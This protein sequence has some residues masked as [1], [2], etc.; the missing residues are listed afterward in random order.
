[1]PLHPPASRGGGDGRRRHDREEG[2]RLHEQVAHE[3]VQRVGRPARAEH[4]L[5]GP[6]RTHAL[7]R[8]EDEGEHEEVQQE[9]VEPERHAAIDRA[10][11]GN[12]GTAEERRAEAQREPRRGQRLAPPQN[13]GDHPEEH[14]GAD[15]ELN[16][17]SDGRH[18]VACAEIHVREERGVMQAE[19]RAERQQPAEDRRGPARPPRPECVA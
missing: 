12:A 11:D 16:E 19:Y 3:E 13:R 1:M 8:D 17:R 14:P 2:R 4:P 6:L 18:R 5:L 15:D 10:V 7:E 9:P